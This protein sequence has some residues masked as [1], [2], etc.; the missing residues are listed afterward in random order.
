MTD[1]PKPLGQ[2][3]PDEMRRM[4]EAIRKL[5]SRS[6][7]ID[8]GI[9]VHAL[10]AVIDPAYTTGQPK[11]LINGAA[12]LSG[13]YPVLAGYTPHAS[14]QVVVLPLRRSYVVLGKYT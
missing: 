12:T 4:R 8:S 10:P 3:F 2:R 9:A 14:D 1:Y 7:S 11:V 13:P 6:S 5:Q